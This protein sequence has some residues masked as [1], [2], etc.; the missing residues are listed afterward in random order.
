VCHQSVGLIARCT[1]A[2]GI[3]TL[4]MGSALD[5]VKAVNPPRF[6]FLDFPL[7][8]P[9]G[10]PHEPELQ[11]EILVQALEGFTTMTEPGSIKVLPFRWSDA[12]EWKNS[13]MTDGDS[14]IPRYDTPQ[15]QTAEDRARA[16]AGSL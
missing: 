9:T 10:K 4:C 12:D 11:R 13:A 7:G 15:Y 8:H 14:R 2:A 1:E 5:I 6:A 16:D 3:P